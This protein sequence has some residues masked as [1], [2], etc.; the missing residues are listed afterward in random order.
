[1]K[2]KPELILPAGDP[3]KARFAF[4]YGADAVYLGLGKY[5]MRKT[6]VKYTIAEIDQ[7][8]RLAHKL[9]KRVYITFNIFAHEE[10]LKTLASDVKKIAK[11][12]PNAF[13]IAD[14]GIL[15]IVRKN[16]PKIPIHISTQQSTVNAEAVKFWKSIGVKRVIL[17]RE[18]TLKEI[19]KIHKEVPDIEL[20]MFVHG[21]MC[22][23]YSGRCLLSTYMTGREANLGDCAQPCRWNYKVHSSSVIPSNSSSEAL[24]KLE[25]EEPLKKLKRRGSLHS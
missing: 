19:A 11:L 13:V 25:T 16:A 2:Q 5:S 9:G 20:E 6:E 15:N 14:M 18:L 8:I 21:A 24:T 10:H 12:E 7:T 17:A 3:E 22:I 1:M 4:E 23:S